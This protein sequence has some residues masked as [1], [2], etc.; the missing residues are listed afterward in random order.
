MSDIFKTVPAETVE[1]E[2]HSEFIENYRRVQNVQ[3]EKF[4]KQLK[5]DL[6][7]LVV[8]H[9][10]CD[11][12][13]QKNELGDEIRELKKELVLWESKQIEI[14]MPGRMM[15][16]DKN[17]LHQCRRENTFFSKGNAASITIN[18]EMSQDDIIRMR[19]RK[20]IGNSKST[21]LPENVLGE[22]NRMKT[23]I[24]REKLVKTSSKGMSRVLAP[25]HEDLAIE[26]GSDL[27]MDEEFM[28][29]YNESHKLTPSS[30]P[31]QEISML[32]KWTQEK[33]PKVTF[34]KGLCIPLAVWKMLFEHQQ[35][36]LQWLFELH[37]LGV[38][39]IL[40]DEMGLGK[41][42][43]ISVFIGALHFSKLLHG[44]SLIVCPA[45]VLAQW[46]KELQHWIPCVPVFVLHQSFEKNMKIIDVLRKATQN[47][48]IIL[49]TYA[50]LNIHAQFLT[51]LRQL[52]Y[53][54]LDE[55]HLIRNTEIQTAKVCHRLPTVHRIVSTGT[56]IQNSLQELWGIFHF[57]HPGLLGTIATFNSIFH[58]PIRRG[59]SP[60]A[61]RQDVRDAYEFSRQLKARIAPFFL[62]RLKEEVN[63][64]LKG[65]TEDILYVKL[66]DDQLT[67]Y[68]TILMSRKL[69]EDIQI[70]KSIHF[71]GKSVGRADIFSARSAQLFRTIIFLRKICNHAWLVRES[72]PKVT[73]ENLEECLHGSAKLRVLLDF[74]MKWRA[75]GEKAIVYSQSLSLLDIIE[76]CIS[77]INAS[78]TSVPVHY[79]RIDGDTAI[80]HRSALINALNHDPN[81]HLGLL[82][83]RVGGLGI[84]LTGCSK[85]VL[86]DPDWN[87]IIDIQARERVWRY[88]Q[89]RDVSIYRFITAG[90]IEEKIYHRQLHK[91]FM[92]QSVLSKDGVQ[93]SDMLKFSPEEV[94]GLF[95]LGAEYQSQGK[96]N[97][98]V[99]KKQRPTAVATNQQSED[100]MHILRSVLDAKSVLHI[101]SFDEVAS[102]LGIDGS[103]DRKNAEAARRNA[104][105]QAQLLGHTQR[106]TRDAPVIQNYESCD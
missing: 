87:P 92:M 10:L 38:G 62:R 65:K 49:T 6:K 22:R 68:R 30:M 33:Q 105:R 51:T 40:A 99:R 70:H 74:I 77:S 28:E 29:V 48:C 25:A 61:T 1:Q 15:H 103:V 58:D 4:L 23:Y 60:R 16:G 80:A 17:D 79:V 37:S 64:Q 75:Q 101:D 89:Q 31:A 3:N 45:T 2:A 90:T 88:G 7:K 47:T 57:V 53:V 21:N 44:I 35:V 27:E 24:N 52:H 81:V 73:P 106:P 102:K 104:E 42:I 95:S 54:F 41:T 43:E 82:T 96:D 59:S 46:L 98:V 78:S 69:R 8:Q 93:F 39:G 97:K 18:P 26:I 91:L 100:P 13:E 71:L 83:T 34:R 67:Q 5:T 66:T 63:M 84:N 55:G 9:S 36:A 72:I 56:P 32:E 94:T 85:V 11:D 50:M 12:P 86:F 20:R 19:S 76:Q 14:T